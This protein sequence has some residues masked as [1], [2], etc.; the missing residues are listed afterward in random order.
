MTLWSV[1][2]VAFGYF[3]FGQL[4]WLRPFVRDLAGWVVHPR[5]SGGPAIPFRWWGGLAIGA[6][7]IV[8]GSLLARVTLRRTPLASSRLA[9]LG[10]GLI[11]GPCLLG[12][13]G[14]L[15]DVLGQLR[16]WFLGCLLVGSTVLICGLWQ[17]DH[18]FAAKRRNLV[19]ESTPEARQARRVSRPDVAVFCLAALVVVLM[20]I[21]VAMSPIIEW[22]AIVYHAATAKLW[23]LGRPR[24]PTLFGPSVGVEISNNYPPLFPATGAFFYV[25]LNHFDDFYLRVLPPIVFTGLLLITHAYAR[26]RFGNAA[27]RWSVLVMLGCPILV[28]YGE[29]PTSYVYLTALTTLVVILI[30]F[31]ANAS[32][33]AMW[34]AAGCA[35][36][37]AAL[38][39][40]YGLLCLPIGVIGYLVLSQ[41]R[42]GGWA[43]PGCFVLISLLVASPWF[44]R[45][46]ILLG[47]PVYPLAS[48]PFHA[49]GLSR[50]LWAS[51]QAEIRNNALGFWTSSPPS[52]IGLVLRLRELGTAFVN[53]NLLAGGVLFAG[54]V[55]V[56]ACWQRRRTEMYLLL[57][58]LVLVGVQLI[59]GWYWLR[60]L[61]P[62]MPVA[63]LLSGRGLA[64]LERP[65][66]RILGRSAS[67]FWASA[68]I[69]R[70]RA[71]VLVLATVGLSLAIIGPDAPTWPT[72]LTGS[73]NVMQGVVDLGSTSKTLQYVFSGD[74]QCWTWLNARLGGSG[75]VATFD[76]RL[77]YFNRPGELFYLDGKEA[78]PLLRESSMPSIA[79]YLQSHGVKY[80]YVPSWA[81]APGAPREPIIESMPLIRDLG[82]TQF[83]LVAA[84]S[85]GEYL[86]EIYQVGGSGASSSSFSSSV[87]LKRISARPPGSETLEVPANQ[88]SPR[89]YVHV[90]T[91]PKALEFSYRQTGPGYFSVNNFNYDR[92]GWNNGWYLSRARRSSSWST[93]LIPLVPTGRS[94]LVD[95]GLFAHRNSVL[96]RGIK[97][98]PFL[99]PELVIGGS[100]VEVG[101]PIRIRHRDTSPRLYLPPGSSDSLR[102]AYLAGEHERV[103]MN[104]YEVRSNTWRYDVA[105]FY[106]RRLHQWTTVTFR[107]PGRRSAVTDLGI[108]VP[109]SDIE[110]R[111][112]G[113]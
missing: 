25:L 98:V 93:A 109:R 22:D 66:G 47:D 2:L 54:V 27:A 101:A 85:V 13:L 64:L 34:V 46:G 75:R 14:S 105:T 5:I 65:A 84:F 15:A 81:V 48:P 60:A 97:V 67:R 82:S 3:T 50:T 53:R 26:I 1:L 32:G 28:M 112:L 30:D 73:T 104:V 52:I 40:F 100:P 39:S 106:T 41:R 45:N 95:L 35:S 21:H 71:L 77:Y 12:A 23:F 19:A 92:Q 16:P 56:V 103:T 17:M 107:V 18:R 36:G 57:V 89:I 70:S 29:W 4:S 31:A 24:P 90:A 38:S 94:S 43:R 111:L 51:S 76:N 79:R 108:F 80:V 88:T 102:V 6:L 49:V 10:A 68:E 69:A 58:T 55:G 7:A 91:K 110:F 37:L 72:D 83:P 9:T 42:R 63:A 61:L 99:R 96:I 113:S 11:V 74:Y 86:S 44:L 78:V 59:P 20:L 8:L 87:V 62:A 33:Y